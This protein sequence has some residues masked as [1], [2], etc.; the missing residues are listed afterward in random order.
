M[1]PSFPPCDTIYLA[2]LPPGDSDWII[3]LLRDS[4]AAIGFKLAPRRNDQ[5]LSLWLQFGSIERARM[6]LEFT[7]R[8]GDCGKPWV[9]RFEFSKNPLWVRTEDNPTWQPPSNAPTG[10]RAQRLETLAG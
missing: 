10:P 3:N 2:C 5:H 9:P 7:S 1:R 8:M 6:A 4:F